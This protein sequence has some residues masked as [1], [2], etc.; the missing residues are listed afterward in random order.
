MKIARTP[1]QFRE[2]MRSAFEYGKEVVES[3]TPVSIDV[4][5]HQSKRGLSPNALSWVWYG[6]IAKHMG[7]SVDEVHTECKLTMGVPILRAENAE[8]RD[9]YDQVLKGHSYADKLM[10]VKFLP[11]TS[12]MTKSQMARYLDDMQQEFTYQGIALQSREDQDG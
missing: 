6:Q 4:K 2:M 5:R 1:E 12:I 8:F 9:A 10:I 3:G 7:Q 11:V